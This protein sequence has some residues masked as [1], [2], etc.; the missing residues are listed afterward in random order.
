[1]P[2]LTSTSAQFRTS[3]IYDE[4]GESLASLSTPL[5]NIGGRRQFHGLV[6][7]IHCPGDNALLKRL[8]T[9]S[10]DGAVL[11]VDGGGTLETELLGGS[12][13]QQMADNDWAGVI[14]YGAI[15]DRHEIAEIPIGVKALGS[16][17]RKSS[18]NGTGTV[19]A[20][21]N[22]SGVSIVPGSML[23]A[24]DDGILVERV[25]Q[26]PSEQCVRLDSLSSDRH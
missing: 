18:K 15:R 2:S 25:P 22:L 14:V 7:T 9:K 21:L 26:F 4:F 13:A 11:V 19:D 6:R 23:Y 16:N 17:P 1:M 10:G 20:P 5:E 12:M 3:D 24:D 8:I